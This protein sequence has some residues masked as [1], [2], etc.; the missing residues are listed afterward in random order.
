MCGAANLQNGENESE[1]PGVSSPLSRKS[2]LAFILGDEPAPTSKRKAGTAQLGR[3]ETS[4]AATKRKV[5]P[6]GSQQKQKAK[7]E[8]ATPVAASD[9]EQEESRDAA[10]TTPSVN[11]KNFS[12]FRI[13]NKVVV[14]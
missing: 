3:S 6:R 4:P 1:N 10:R 11:R 8:P 7:R 5:T 14:L 13:L 2:S 9:A 12:E